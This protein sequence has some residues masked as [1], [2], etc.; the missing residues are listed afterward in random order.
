MGIPVRGRAF[1]NHDR[2]GALPVA[3]V[4]EAFA[5]TFW[6][7]EN[8]VGKRIK[9]GRR[10]SGAPWM[11]VIGVAGDVHQFGMESSPRPEFYV[12]YLQS[13]DR[14]FFMPRDLVVRTAGDPRSLVAMVRAEIRAI[15]A[16][17]PLVDIMT[18]N[19][20]VAASVAQRRF[21]T[22][23]I[24][25]FAGIALLLAM[26]GTYGV[27]SHAVARRTREIG[28]RVALGA[29]APAILRM[30]LIQAAKPA[31]CGIAFGLAGALVAGNLI[32]TQLYGVT[33]FDAATFIAVTLA[34]GGAVLLATL[35][36]ARRS[37]RVE[38]I[39]AMRSG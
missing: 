17:V 31:V 22:L 21:N 20:I 6:P 16:E 28:V 32:A 34:L 35:I 9:N 24:G 12:S 33:A 2:M 38:P 14:G 10:D 7:G 37:L 36:P 3:V 4:N 18:G 5:R 30:V 26:V 25:S 19:D 13:G 23:L 29:S 1:D 15:D 8:A 39:V 11:T 27:V